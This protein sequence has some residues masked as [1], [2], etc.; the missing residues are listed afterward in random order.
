[1]PW[2]SCYNADSGVALGFCTSDKYPIDVNA[3]WRTSLRGIYT[4]AFSFL[5]L[6]VCSLANHNHIL[7]RITKKY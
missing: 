4:C 1:M 7:E 3:S 6:S 2:G 5:N